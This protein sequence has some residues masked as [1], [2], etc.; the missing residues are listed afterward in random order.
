MHILFRANTMLAAR[1]LL[2]AAH[3]D[4]PLDKILKPTSGQ[5]HRLLGAAHSDDPLDKLLKPTSAKDPLDNILFDADTASSHPKSPSAASHTGA[6]HSASH[7]AASHSGMS[8]SDAQILESAIATE[9]K[10]N[11]NELT[12]H[13]FPE[14]SGIVHTEFL[15]HNADAIKLGRQLEKK[16]LDNEFAPLPR[17]PIHRL[18][19]E[20]VFDCG[21]HAVGATHTYDGTNGGEHAIAWA[22]P[23]SGYAPS[24][25]LR[26]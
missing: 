13:Q 5:D 15:F 1:R 7:S 6:S 25:V 2:D 12:M 16:V 24:G 8:Y 9:L 20:E 11:I 26:K 17:Q 3:S 23:D 21:E 19:L 10:L 18:Y 22:L 14:P 4:D